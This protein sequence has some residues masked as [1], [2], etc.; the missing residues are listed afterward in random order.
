MV[1][2][3]AQVKIVFTVILLRHLGLAVNHQIRMVHGL[4][5][6]N[7]NVKDMCIVVQHRAALQIGVELGL[8]LGVEGRVEILFF[9]VQLLAAHG[10]HTRRKLDV[11]GAGGLGATQ[12]NLVQHLCVEKCEE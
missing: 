9:H 10:H 1:I 12:Q 3:V 7:Q 5:E 6:T 8:G 11:L 2:A 4:S